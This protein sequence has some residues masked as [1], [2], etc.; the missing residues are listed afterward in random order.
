MIEILNWIVLNDKA[1][2]AIFICVIWGLWVIGCKVEDIIKK[3]KG[4]SAKT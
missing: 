4:Q 1:S 3:W 2:F